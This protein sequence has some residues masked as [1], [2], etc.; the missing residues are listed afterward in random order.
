M[1]NVVPLSYGVLF[2]QVFSEVRFFKAFV[3]DVI[4]FEPD[5]DTVHAEYEYPKP[6]GFVRSRYDLFAEDTKNRVVIEIQHVKEMDFFDRFLYYH[7]TSLIE[8]AGGHKEY[9]FQR[10]VY[11][12]VVLTS[13]PR[14]KSIDFSCAV[15][16][17]NPIDE[18]GNTVNVYPHRLI[19]LCPRLANDSTPP[20]AKVWLDFIADSLDEK[21]DESDYQQQ[22]FDE[23]LQRIRADDIDRDTL[24]DLKDESAWELTLRENQKAALVE[25]A[26]SLLANGVD[27][28]TVFASI[29]IKPEDLDKDV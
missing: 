20:Q 3:K 29:N 7:L 1:I 27:P 8:Q 25:A 18:H 13:V 19:F 28:E 5:I 10:T 12:I 4:G 17:M 21:M 2:K 9:E 23:L 16:E 22:P 26:R 15:S 6:V 11:T 14:D 24:A